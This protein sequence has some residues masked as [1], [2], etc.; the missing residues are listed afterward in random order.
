V[1]RHTRE[2][3]IGHLTVILLPYKAREW[4]EPLP[5]VTREQACDLITSGAEG[6]VFPDFNHRPI[7]TAHV[8]RLRLALPQTD[9]FSSEQGA[10]LCNWSL[11]SE[12]K[13]PRE[14]AIHLIKHG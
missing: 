3:A 12:P 5:P 10:K 2:Q 11:T 1:I 9:P 13:A 6:D 4:R 14:L 8:P 7:A